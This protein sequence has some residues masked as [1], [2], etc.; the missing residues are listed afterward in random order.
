MYAW[1]CCVLRGRHNPS[2]HPL[3]GFRCLDCGRAGA[4]LE[5]MGFQGQAYL[6]QS[7][8]ALARDA[9]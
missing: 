3:G 1:L 5:D 8:R 2:R 7:R 4:D 6:R 9:D